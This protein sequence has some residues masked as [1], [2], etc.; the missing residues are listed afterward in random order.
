MAL[1]KQR[2]NAPEENHVRVL[3]RKLLVRHHKMTLHMKVF[4]WNVFEFVSKASAN[5]KD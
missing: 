3:S 4:W 1:Q 2:E 5:L